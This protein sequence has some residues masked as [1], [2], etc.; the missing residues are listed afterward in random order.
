MII[1]PFSPEIAQTFG[2][3]GRSDSLNNQAMNSIAVGDGLAV[4]PFDGAVLVKIEDQG[5]L[6]AERE[7]GAEGCTDGGLADATLR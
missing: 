7:G 3:A 6:T 2:K 4:P 1:P 5:A